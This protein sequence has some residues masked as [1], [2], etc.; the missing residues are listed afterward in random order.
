[1]GAQGLGPIRLGLACAAALAAKSDIA[2]VF[3]TRHEQE[4]FDIPDLNL[5]NGQD[6]LIAA[7]SEI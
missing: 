7:V 5:P 4:G 6:A 3:V 1:M 2:I